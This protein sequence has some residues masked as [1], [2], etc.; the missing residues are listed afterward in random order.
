MYLK[1]SRFRIM[2]VLTPLSYRSSTLVIYSHVRPA[3]RLLAIRLH[4]H[5]ISLHLSQ[6]NTP[7]H[8]VPNVRLL[9]LGNHTPALPTRR[10]GLRQTH[11]QQPWHYSWPWPVSECPRFTRPLWQAAIIL[12]SAS[13]E[14]ETALLPRCPIARRRAGA[15]EVV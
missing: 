8:L 3:P 14:L 9:L 4:F 15:G 11:T 7:S 5:P 1:W 6:P 12:H 2:S 13:S 10:H